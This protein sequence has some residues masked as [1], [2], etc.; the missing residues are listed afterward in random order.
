[1]RRIAR[2]RIFI[3]SKFTVSNIVLSREIRI[4]SRG[5]MNL[6]IK[7]YSRW[8]ETAQKST[9]A[10]DEVAGYTTYANFIESR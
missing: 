6:D 5:S 1:M 7:Q 10:D 8:T 3:H 2:L 9:H 4:F